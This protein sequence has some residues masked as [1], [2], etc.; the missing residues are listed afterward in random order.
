MGPIS[1]HLIS[2]KKGKSRGPIPD[3]RFANAFIFFPTT[4]LT[5]TTLAQKI[6]YGNWPTA[7]TAKWRLFFLLVSGS[8]GNSCILIKEA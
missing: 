2:S 1:N 5:A 4:P 8:S 3:S 6:I 7:C